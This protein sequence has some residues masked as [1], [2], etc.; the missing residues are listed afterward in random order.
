MQPTNAHPIRDPCKNAA[1]IVTILLKTRVTIHAESTLGGMPRAIYMFLLFSLAFCPHSS[2]QTRIH[3]NLS[4]D[5]GTLLGSRFGGMPRAKLQFWGPKTEEA[6][7][8][9]EREPPR[10]ALLLIRNNSPPPCG[11][12]QVAGQGQGQGAGFGVWC[13]AVAV[14]VCVCVAVAVA[15]A[16]C[17]VHG[18]WW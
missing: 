10:T 5:R 16:W 15:G 8:D 18:V 2:C 9:P 1:K 7:P 11:M 3:R 4:T 6:T 13:V 17:M 14:C 12:W